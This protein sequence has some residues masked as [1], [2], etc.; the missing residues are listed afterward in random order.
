MR[1]DGMLCYDSLF[2]SNIIDNFK[3]ENKA[4]KAEI[5]ALREELEKERQ[6]NESSN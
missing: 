4:L 5:E 2:I 3:T 6:K 1:K